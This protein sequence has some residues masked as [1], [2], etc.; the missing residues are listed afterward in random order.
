MSAITTNFNIL[1]NMF[2]EV[3]NNSIIETFTNK[4]EKVTKDVVIK[5]CK[6]AKIDVPKELFED[7]AETF[8][9]K[10]VDYF[11]SSKNFKPI[12]YDEETVY[13]D[14][15]GNKAL[16]GNHIITFNK[17]DDDTYEYIFEITHEEE[18][19]TYS[20]K[21]TTKKDIIDCINKSIA[22]IENIDEYYN[23]VEELQELL[24]TI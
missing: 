22:L 3:S 11:G 23:Y 6:N 8:I 20:A 9:E 21:I 18:T 15:I 16:K 5:F 1:K 14:I 19:L 12:K 24:K 13:V 4:D 17:E 10:S 2:N 7:Q